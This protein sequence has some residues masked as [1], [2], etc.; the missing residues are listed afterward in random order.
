MGKQ[1]LKVG[2]GYNPWS[3]KERRHD[4]SAICRRYGGGGHPAV[5]AFAL[6]TKA[7]AKAREAA[8]A[9]VRELNET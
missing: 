1:Q 7:L 9:I 4:I 8:D 2:V 6:P 5:G 3:G